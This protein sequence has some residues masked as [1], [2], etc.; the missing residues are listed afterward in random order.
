[1]KL[2]LPYVRDGVKHGF[3]YLLET[4]FQKNWFS[5]TA[6]HRFWDSLQYY[7]LDYLFN[8]PACLLDKE[9]ADEAV[10]VSL[11]N[12]EEA[13]IIS[14]Y[15]NFFNDT[16]EGEMPDSYYVNHP[17]WPKVIEGAKQ[18]LEMIEKNNKKYDLKRDLALWD[19]KYHPEEGS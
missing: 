16:F 10:G 19:E 3:E 11:Y 18:I 8:S 5:S 9:E 2:E 4:E 1:M 17:E 7:V 12:Q 6:K 13:D 15:L 14:S